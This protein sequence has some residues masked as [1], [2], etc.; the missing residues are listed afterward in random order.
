[1]KKIGLFTTITLLLVT[2]LLAGC[3]GKSAMPYEKLELSEYVKIEKYIGIET[4][5][6]S[7][8]SDDEMAVAVKDC[9][10][11]E[12]VYDLGEPV[13]DRPIKEGDCVT[14]DIVGTIDGVAFEGGTEKDYKI[15]TGLNSFSTWNDYLINAELGEVVTVKF[16][17]PQNESEY[18][19]ASGKEIYYNL[20]IKEICPVVYPQLTPEVVSEVSGHSTEEEFLSF[21]RGTIEEKRFNEKM[22]DV[23]KTVMSNV[24]IIDYPQEQIDKYAENYREQ[25]NIKAKS[26]TMSLDEYLESN[27][28]TQTDL[29]KEAMEYA[30]TKVGEELVCYYIAQEEGITVTDEDYEK[31]LE[32]LYN[33][34]KHLYSSEKDVEKEHGEEK[35]RF[36]ILASKVMTFVTEKAVE[37]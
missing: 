12:D 26:S 19:D 4:T 16:S 1:M 31:E 25:I 28:K 10:Y 15:I 6:T 5:I 21:L 36:G 27:D 9:L 33:E 3:L 2:F 37:V 7:I 18:G 11:N 14:V 23:W 17:I 24:E 35:I 32:S 8:V 29:D 20:K 22:D 34:K 13:T 30:K